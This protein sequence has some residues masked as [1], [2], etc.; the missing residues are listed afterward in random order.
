MSIDSVPLSGVSAPKMTESKDL[1]PH[2]DTAEEPPSAFFPGDSMILLDLC[3]GA[4][5]FGKSSA[6]FP[7]QEE[8]NIG[9]WG[10]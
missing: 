5:Q 3:F 10:Y 9:G 6:K 4:S 2:C 7:A 8:I 1:L